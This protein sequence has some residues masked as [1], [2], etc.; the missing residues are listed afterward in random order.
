MVEKRMKQLLNVVIL[1][2]NLCEGTSKLSIMDWNYEK[3]EAGYN[4]PFV[5]GVYDSFDVNT[6][7]SM[8]DGCECLDDINGVNTT[9]LYG[10]GGCTEFTRHV[11]GSMLDCD[12]AT[13]WDCTKEAW[14]WVDPNNCTGGG[15]FFPA[16]DYDS[17]QDDSHISLTVAQKSWN[18]CGYFAANSTRTTNVL[19][20]LRGETLKVVVV[21][22][23]SKHI[24]GVTGVDDISSPVMR[25]WESIA[26]A[27]GFDYTTQL[28]S[29]A[30]Q[31]A[32]PNSKSLQAA[33]DVAMGDADVA[34]GYFTP[35]LEHVSMVTILPSI[36]SENLYLGSYIGIAEADYFRLLFPFTSGLWITC[37][38]IVLFTGVL[39]GI[40]EY[41]ISIG[42]WFRKGW[43]L[44]E[45]IWSTINYS[46]G[47]FLNYDMGLPQSFE[48]RLL[49][50]VFG[51]F[52]LLAEAYYISNLTA[53]TL[54]D[55]LT[56]VYM[57]VDEVVRDQGRICVVEDDIKMFLTSTPFHDANLVKFDTLGNMPDSL[58]SGKCT[59]IVT[60]TMRHWHKDGDHCDIRAI[61]GS[62]FK[63]I[64]AGAGVIRTLPKAWMAQDKYWETLAFYIVHGKAEWSSIMLNDLPDSACQELTFSSGP[65]SDYLVFIVIWIA[66]CFIAAVVSNVNEDDYTLEEPGQDVVAA[67]NKN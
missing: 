49:M 60:D 40:F 27:A 17:F 12:L 58:K 54:S 29:E 35:T 64:A 3:W 2:L 31:I 7:P 57:N 25:F 11:D 43:T 67:K 16:D 15:E 42:W 32:H 39:L 41:G 59:A 30:A 23:D 22:S 24:K 38:S 19:D 18:S 62:D 53:L 9:G 66:G 46:I 13:N 34:I 4:G 28:P 47:M 50:A 20:G 56:G 61:K 63:S 36:D 6:Y 45:T 48:G 55:T 37:I 52:T 21:L 10:F 26:L 33:Y 44:G 5:E 8:I 65:M 14:C 51:F 1:L